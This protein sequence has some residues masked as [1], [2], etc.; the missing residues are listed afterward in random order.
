ML[1]LHVAIYLQGEELPFIKV[2]YG[3]KMGD[4]LAKLHEYLGE[5][6]DKVTHYT[7]VDVFRY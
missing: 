1:Y 6:G 3:E 5:K 7:V 4:A 2:F